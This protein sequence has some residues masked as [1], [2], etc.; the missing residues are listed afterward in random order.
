MGLSVSAATGIIVLAMIV[1]ISFLCM[2]LAESFQRVRSAGEDRISY[3]MAR[4][5]TCITIR[6]INHT[7]PV[8]EIYVVN[9]GSQ[10]IAIGEMSILLDGK[11][12]MKKD[13][14]LSVDGKK[15]DLLMHGETLTIRIT[16]IL[17]RPSTIKVVTGNGVEAYG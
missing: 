1:S 14:N 17:T 16:N 2:S 6:G 7:P 5:R 12:I 8:L 4:E 9:C 15:T 11:L 3:L 10:T 13:M